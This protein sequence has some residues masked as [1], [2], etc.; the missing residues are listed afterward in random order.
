[1]H[2]SRVLDCVAVDNVVF[3][4]RVTIDGPNFSRIGFVHLRLQKRACH[5]RGHHVSLDRGPEARAEIMVFQSVTEIVHEEKP[6]LLVPVAVGVTSQHECAVLVPGPGHHGHRGVD[7]GD[8]STSL[9][10]S[11]E[12]TDNKRLTATVFQVQQNQV[13]I[14]QNLIL[15]RLCKNLYDLVSDVSRHGKSIALSKD[16]LAKQ[17]EGVLVLLFVD[18]EWCHHNIIVSNRVVGNIFKE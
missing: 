4:V 13:T 2:A 9:R 7:H 3:R 12:S 17:H 5:A 15:L 6:V 11:V 16:G 18:P 1:M 10:V 14:R 8:G